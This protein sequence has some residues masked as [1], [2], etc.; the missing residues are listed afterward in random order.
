MSSVLSGLGRRFREY[1]ALLVSGD[2]NAIAWRLQVKMRRLD[3]NFVPENELGV[4]GSRANSYSDSGARLRAVL[5]K[6]PIE[7]SSFALDL[8]CGKGG[9]VL[10]LA[11]RFTRADGVDISPSLVAIGRENLRRM[12]VKNGSLNVCDAAEFTDLD[13]SPAV[14]SPFLF[15]LYNVGTTVDGRHYFAMEFSRGLK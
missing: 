13:G 4:T 7:P 6:I 9:A 8:G 14:E 2:L 5:K 15:A 12:G 11:S 3:F 10:V 1:A